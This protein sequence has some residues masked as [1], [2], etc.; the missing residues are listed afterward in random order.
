MFLVLNLCL[1]ALFLK[2]PKIK[3]L[4][5]YY[6]IN[7]VLFCEKGIHVIDHATCIEEIYVV[8]SGLEQGYVH[9]EHTWQ[10]GCTP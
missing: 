6:E 1:I 7:I 2:T 5:G 9:L 10:A 4:K 3:L 8:Q